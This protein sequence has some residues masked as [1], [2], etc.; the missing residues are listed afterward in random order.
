MYVRRLGLL[1][2]WTT[3]RLAIK[4][5]SLANDHQNVLAYFHSR[6][7]S[8]GHEIANAAGDERTY[9]RAVQAAGKL[10]QWQMC[11]DMLY[12]LIG[13]IYKSYTYIFTYIYI[14]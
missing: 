13:K 10:R 1:L 14:L 9:V 3:Q 8:I 2:L 4:T 5:F 12:E 6:R 7:N 11:I